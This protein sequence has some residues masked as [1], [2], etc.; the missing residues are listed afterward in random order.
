MLTVI[1]A[2]TVIRQVAGRGPE[3]GG[4]LAFAERGC[5]GRRKRP[6]SRLGF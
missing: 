6:P 3:E 1:G 4:L 5:L 2:V